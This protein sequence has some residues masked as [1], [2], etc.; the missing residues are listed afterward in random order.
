MPVIKLLT[1]QSYF[2]QTL[3]EGSS[4]RITLSIWPFHE[5]FSPSFS[6]RTK[7][8][9]T[10]QMRISFR[11]EISIVVCRYFHD[12]KP[13]W[14]ASS[15]RH[16]LF[17]ERFRTKALRQLTTDDRV[18]PFY[19][20]CTQWC[21]SALRCLGRGCGTDSFE[22]LSLG[23]PPNFIRWVVKPLISC[24]LGDNQWMKLLTSTP[25]F[26]CICWW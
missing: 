11:I 24:P 20:I 19:Q 25:W 4:Q 14:F 8:P 3:M 15:F 6:R 9:L 17:A 26:R 5:S 2:I 10:R 7:M 18:S 1:D 21:P 23:R 22:A 16:W 13:L 12:T